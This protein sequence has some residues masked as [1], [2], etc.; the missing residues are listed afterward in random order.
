[1][2]E[3]KTFFWHVLSAYTGLSSDLTASNGKSVF[4]NQ[5]YPQAIL[6]FFKVISFLMISEN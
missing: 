3:Y 6:L 5:H 4:E 2:C 1:M